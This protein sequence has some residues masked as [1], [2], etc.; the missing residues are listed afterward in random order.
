[1]VSSETT[2]QARCSARAAVMQFIK[3]QS[4]QLCPTTYLRILSAQGQESRPME[5]STESDVQSTSLVKSLAAPPVDTYLRM[6]VRHHLPKS[7]PQIQMGK[8]IRK[9]RLD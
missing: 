3:S 8:M 2:K 6:L 7:E 9:F 1:M 5:R 4:L